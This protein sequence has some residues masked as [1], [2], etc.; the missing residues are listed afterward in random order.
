VLADQLD[1]WA[2]AAAWA[3]WMEGGDGR[4]PRASRGKLTKERTRSST[5]R[6]PRRSP[7]TASCT[8]SDG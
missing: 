2:M 8:R 3:E 5:S 7:S 4:P 6:G 1:S